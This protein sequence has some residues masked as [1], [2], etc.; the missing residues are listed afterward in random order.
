MQKY[1]AN[2]IIKNGLSTSGF[3]QQKVFRP[4]YAS[5]TSDVESEYDNF[6]EASSIEEQKQCFQ[7]FS[8]EV[9]DTIL[10]VNTPSLDVYS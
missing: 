3:V 9:E 6:F 5:R 7:K 8:S 2:E 10:S 1:F 4:I